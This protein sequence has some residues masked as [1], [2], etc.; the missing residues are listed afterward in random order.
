MAQVLKKRTGPK[1]AERR[2][3]EGRY[4]VYI[5]TV[6]GRNARQFAHKLD[7]QKGYQ[8]YINTDKKGQVTSVE[9]WMED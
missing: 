4:Y 2:R 3:M 9:F 1:L 8:A 6:R 7:N 5:R